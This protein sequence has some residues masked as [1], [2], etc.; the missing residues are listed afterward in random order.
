MVGSPVRVPARAD[1]HM[2]YCPHTDRHDSRV[3]SK[4]VGQWPKFTARRCVRPLAMVT[5]KGTESGQAIDIMRKN[6]PVHR[7]TTIK[8]R[9]DPMMLHAPP[10][11]LS[12][13][14]NCTVSVLYIFVKLR[15]K[16]NALGAVNL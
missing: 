11:Q 8:S 12:V 3:V 6:S 14:V 5:T 4:H 10:A 2:D 15:K 13:T 7:R 1:R 16:K 9:P